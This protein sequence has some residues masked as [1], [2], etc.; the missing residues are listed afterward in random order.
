MLTFANEAALELGDQCR[1]QNLILSGGVR[2]FLDGY[3]LLS[4]AH[5]P[6]VYGQASELLRHARADYAD[7][8]A[9]VQAQVR[10]LE[11]A[12]AFLQVKYGTLR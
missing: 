11:L 9:F 7:L 2:D 8:Q 10:G 4:S 5:L 12:R 1:V 3:Y 6:A